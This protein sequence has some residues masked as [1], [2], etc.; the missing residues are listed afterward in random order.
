[1]TEMNKDFVPDPAT[2]PVS[3]RWAF[4]LWTAAGV[5]LAALGAVSLV[6]ELWSGWHLGLMAVE[7]LVAAVGAAYIMLARRAM[8]RQQWRGA[9][10]ALTFVVVVMLLVLTI[11]FRSSGLAVVLAVAV[12]GFWGT[13]LAYR[14]KA[15]AW[16]N[17]RDVNGSGDDQA[18]PR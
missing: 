4:G 2:R 10:A 11:G 7:V 14:P 1:M 8:C 6:T 12:L 5:L 18:D 3:V 9:L 15:D 13:V 17:G 16:F